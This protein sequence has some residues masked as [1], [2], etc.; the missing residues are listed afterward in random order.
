LLT[1][2]VATASDEEELAKATQNPVA[3]LISLPFQNNTNFNV[4]PQ[5][6]TQNILNIQTVWPVTLNEEWNLITRTIVPV[7]SQPEMAPGDDR[8]CGLGDTTLPR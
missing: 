1:V 6:K 2:D 5:D 4:G 3:G 7:I 8:E